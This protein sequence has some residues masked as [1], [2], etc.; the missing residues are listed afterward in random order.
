MPLLCVAVWD[1]GAWTVGNGSVEA[2][3]FEDGR[4]LKVTKGRV[5]E[6][7]RGQ[8]DVQGQD[9]RRLEAKLE[10]VSGLS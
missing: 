9:W 7:G 4:E 8:K 6:T 1:G 3:S 10:R 5:R 2:G